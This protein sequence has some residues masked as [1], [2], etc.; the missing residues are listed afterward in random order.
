MINKEILLELDVLVNKLSKTGEV[1]FGKLL[2]SLTLGKTRSQLY[3][4]NDQE[5]IKHIQNVQ[6]RET[7]V[8]ED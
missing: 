3:D 4:M 5:F 2:L 6:L 8:R 7:E 1:T